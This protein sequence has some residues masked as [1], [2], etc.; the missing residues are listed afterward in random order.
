MPTLK[1]ADICKDGISLAHVSR[2]IYSEKKGFK[3]HI[4]KIRAE[5]SKSQRSRKN[6]KNTVS[7]NF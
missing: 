4:S 3:K 7:F 5:L 1:L 6:G 2:S